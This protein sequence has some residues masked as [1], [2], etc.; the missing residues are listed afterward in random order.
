MSETYES[1]EHHRC[2]CDSCCGDL[3]MCG[4]AIRVA[5]VDEPNEFFEGTYI[6]SSCNRL[7][8]RNEQGN[9]ECSPCELVTIQKPNS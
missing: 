7:I 5:F 9:I 1:H 8:W 4:D 3:F 6:S 2:K